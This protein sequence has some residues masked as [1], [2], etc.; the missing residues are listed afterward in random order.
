MNG[1][2]EVVVRGGLVVSIAQAIFGPNYHPPSPPEKTEVPPT[3]SPNFAYQNP[4]GWQGKK[5]PDG[6]VVMLLP[7]SL[8]LALPSKVSRT[9]LINVPVTGGLPPLSESASLMIKNRQNFAPTGFAPIA[10]N[11]S[12]VRCLIANDQIDFSNTYYAA[13]ACKSPNYINQFLYV[14]AGESN[15]RF[16][17]T[18]SVS[19][20]GT[21]TSWMLRR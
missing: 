20:C 12:H 14:G 8:R 7:E 18:P 19:F 11:P 15:Y 17:Q 13:V 16:T 9:E 6:F 10:W 21:R 4:P 1:W 2:S 5:S 3:I